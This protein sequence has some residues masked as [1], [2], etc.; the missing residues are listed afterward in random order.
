MPLQS[1]LLRGDPKLEAAAV[2]DPAHIVPGAK[3]EHVRK[4]QQAL[5]QLDGATIDADGSYGPK[6][7]AAVLAFKQKRAIV[8]RSYQTKADNIVGKMT[9]AT[10]DTELLIQERKPVFIQSINPVSSIRTRR[11]SGLLLAF[12]IGD[13]GTPRPPLTPSRPVGRAAA[14]IVAQVAISPGETGTIQV[15]GGKG[16]NLLRWQESDVKPVAK[17]RNAKQPGAGS[18]YAEVV[19]D[20]EIFTYE[21]TRDIGETFFQ[22]YGPDPPGKRSGVLSVLVLPRRSEYPQDPVPW[23]DSRF[24][25]GLLSVEGTPLNPLPGGKNI[26]IFGRGESNG[27]ADFSTSIKFCVDSPKTAGGT[28]KPGEFFLKP[29][30]DD[31]RK[32]DVGIGPNSAKNIC[33]RNSPIFPVT[34]DEIDRIAKPG[35]RVTF[36]GDLKFVELL[37]MTYIA[38]GRARLIEEGPCGGGFGGVAIIFELNP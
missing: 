38:S 25:S 28:S 18:E 13:S 5:I 37:R 9:M 24:K 26:N 19:A 16:G 3:G 2:S 14:P 4:I 36:A 35:C 20:P 31:P 29:W 15:I 30:T 27:F 7:A 1:Q 8:N 6:T 23:S 21:G 33:C 12:S 11:G 34:T 32:P 10:L 17:L 22:W